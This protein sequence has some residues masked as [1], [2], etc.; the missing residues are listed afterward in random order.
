MAS[1]TRVRAL[2]EDGVFKPLAAVELPNRSEVEIT[3]VDRRAFDAW[4]RAHSER[5]ARRTAGISSAELDADV[6]AAIA[7]T[8]A[9][10]D[11]GT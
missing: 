4:W 11:R 2:Y 5:M 7:E 6:D 10:R 8:R 9:Q 1:P 3:V